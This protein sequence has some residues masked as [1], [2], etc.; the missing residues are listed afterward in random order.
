MRSQLRDFHAAISITT[1]DV[2]C[3]T[4]SWLCKKIL[5]GEVTLT[6]LVIFWGDRFGGSEEETV[7]GRVVILIRA[8]L[9]SLEIS[10][11]DL[12][13]ECVW[14]QVKFLD[15]STLFV[16]CS[17]IPPR[18]STEIYDKHLRIIESVY[19][20]LGDKDSAIL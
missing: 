1:Y 14:A 20:Q 8:S 9:N 17:Y 18:S 19:N 15:G 6:G 5:D 12:D 11:D 16:G 10:F 3:I 4:E 2:I 7:G 13:I